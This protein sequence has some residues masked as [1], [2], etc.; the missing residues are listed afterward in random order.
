MLNRRNV[1]VLISG[2]DGRRSKAPEGSGGMVPRKRFEFVSLGNTISCIYFEASFQ[3]NLKAGQR[4]SDQSWGQFVLCG[5]RFF[6]CKCVV[7]N[8]WI[9]LASLWLFFG[10]SPVYF[11]LWL[12]YYFGPVT[13]I[14]IFCMRY[15]DWDQGTCSQGSLDR[16]PHDG[17]R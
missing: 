16:K 1:T 3:R 4:V 6:L 17:R 2:S 11:T 13:K 8:T 9:K 12:R 14:I 5:G 7:F 15:V 10:F